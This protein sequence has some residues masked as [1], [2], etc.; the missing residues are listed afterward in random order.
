MHLI[1]EGPLLGAIILSPN[2][3][4]T[5]ETDKF[6]FFLLVASFLLSQISLSPQIELFSK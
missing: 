5:R 3:S 6:C 1:R 2:S 4:I